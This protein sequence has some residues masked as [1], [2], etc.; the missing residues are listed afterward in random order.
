MR[1][2]EYENG[3]YINGLIFLEETIKKNNVRHALF[4]CYCGNKF[5]AAINKVR[6]GHTNSCSCLQKQKITKLNKTHGL[7]KNPI[8]NIWKDMK[9]RCLNPKFKGYKNYGGRGISICDEWLN[10]PEK[11]IEW[12]SNNGWKE[13]LEIDRI[14]TNGNYEPENIRF[15]SHAENSRNRRPV[16]ANWDLVLDVRNA[17]LLLGEQITNVELAQ[18]FNLSE[19]SISQIINNTRWVT[20]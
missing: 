14:N 15:I 11:F 18:A 2:I 4:Q 19:K 7:S 9:R 5:Q 3:Q 12:A 10:T 8:Y 20:L 13:G 1:R 6:F 17:K 16:K